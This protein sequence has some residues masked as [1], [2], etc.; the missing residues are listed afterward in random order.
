MTFWEGGGFELMIGFRPV[1][2]WVSEAICWK[3]RG[4]L[5]WDHYAL[6][7]DIISSR[8]KSNATIKISIRPNFYVV[9]KRKYPLNFFN[10]VITASEFFVP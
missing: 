9:N 7:S 4:V 6:I 3:T 2:V 5:E 1:G 8:V 10:F